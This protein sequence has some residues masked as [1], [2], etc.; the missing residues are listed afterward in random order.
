MIVSI[1]VATGENGEIG[2]DNKLLWQIPTDLKIFK[3]TTSGHYI[4]M[5]RKTFE[6]I[7][8]PLPNRTNVVVTRSEHA[9]V[10]GIQFVKTLESALELAKNDIETEVFII[11]G[12]QIYQEAIN[13]NLVDRIYLSQ[14]NYTGVA[15]T[16]F[17][18]PEKQF[19]KKSSTHFE[20]GNDNGPGFSF[21]VWEK[22]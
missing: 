16:F 3:K 19:E 1:I 17:L 4:I 10:E 2:K 5:G 14:V 8:R 18:F 11:G 7:G 22:V 20:A 15:D 12:G 21:Q 6:S 13:K 9:S